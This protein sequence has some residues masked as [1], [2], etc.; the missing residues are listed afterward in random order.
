MQGGAISPLSI[1][2]C[3]AIS[4]LR[5]C[6][7][8]SRQPSRLDCAVVK[9]SNA[10]RISALCFTACPRTGVL[11]SSD[12][13]LCN[14]ARGLSQQR[15][16]EHAPCVFAV[17]PQ[18]LSAIGRLRSC[19]PD[20]PHGMTVL[21]R[22]TP[23]QTASRH[24]ASLPVHKLVFCGL[25][26]TLSATSNGDFP[27]NVVGRMLPVCSLLKPHRALSA[28]GRLRSCRPD[29]PHG[30]TVLLRRTLTQTASRHSAPLP[31]HKLVF[32]GLLMTLSANSHEDFLHN[33]VG[34]MLPV[35]GTGISTVCTSVRC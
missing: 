6:R 2:L 33:V 4:R 34:S 8:F 12:D 10:D 19:R 13:T 31:V 16:W 9:N 35:C 24:S 28:I 18:A 26:M 23:T 30:M 1:E 25:L 22:R 5:S 29:S 3:P 20:S 14:F 27:H 17:K 7:P 32:C 21:L 15:C 11:R